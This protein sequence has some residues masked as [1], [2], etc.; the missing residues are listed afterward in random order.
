[1]NK[2][3]F[4]KIN[5]YNMKVF[6]DNKNLL[7]KGFLNLKAWNKTI[8][9]AEIWEYFPENDRVIAKDFYPLIV[10]LK[11]IEIE[12]NTIIIKLK[13][14][15][16][17]EKK[18]NSFRDILFKLEEIIKSRKL[19][20]PEKSYTAYLFKNGEDKILK[21]IAE[22]SAELILASKGGNSVEIIAETSDL[23][24]HIF[25]LLVYKEVPFD[26]I[27]EELYNRMNK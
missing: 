24:Y 11:N 4:N 5:V 12:D 1:M 15:K 10:D 14:R 13:N 6:D 3:D 16:S 23:I 27:L 18:D 9:N 7:H 22:E 20:L 21:K 2:P 26:R 8:E 25:V 19:E 17:E